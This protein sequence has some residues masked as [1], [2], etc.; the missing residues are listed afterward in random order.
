MEVRLT[1]FEEGGGKKKETSLNKHHTTQ[2]KKSFFLI[3]LLCCAERNF[4]FL[5]E[6]PAVYS[7]EAHAKM[8]LPFYFF[9]QDI[10]HGKEVN[11]IPNMTSSVPDLLGFIFFLGGGLS[12]MPVGNLASSLLWTNKH[13]T[14]VFFSPK[15]VCV[16]VCVR[17]K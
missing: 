17:R 7:P 15:Y 11:S 2:T 9:F 8:C 5:P 16:C 1:L 10:L 4:C 6:L 14:G 12:K 13:R 3:L